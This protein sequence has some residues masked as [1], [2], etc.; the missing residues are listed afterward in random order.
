MAAA[1]AELLVCFCECECECECSLQFGGNRSAVTAGA[2]AR[3]E[4]NKYIGGGYLLSEEEALGG[5]QLIDEAKEMARKK[6]LE[7]EAGTERFMLRNVS[8]SSQRRE[9]ER[10]KMIQSEGFIE[11]ECFVSASTSRM[12]LVEVFSGELVLSWAVGLCPNLITAAF[13]CFCIMMCQGAGTSRMLLVTL[14]VFN[15]VTG[16]GT[17]GYWNIEAHVEKWLTQFSK[18]RESKG[19]K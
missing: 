12:L 8:H 10:D 6:D 4:K 7:L 15:G 16:S 2:G 18:K 19:T 17:H 13:S 3:M 14:E 11:A 1:E 9:K 5:S